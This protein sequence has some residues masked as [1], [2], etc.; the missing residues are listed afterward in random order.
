MFSKEGHKASYPVTLAEIQS[1]LKGFSA[2]KSPG[3]DGWPVEFFQVFFDLAG[4]DIL[5]MVEET[6][7]EGRVSD[8]LNVTFLALIPKSEKPTSFGGFRPIALC[9]LTYKIITK[10]IVARI[11]SSLSFEISKEQFGFL[12]GRQITDA[13]GVVQGSFIQYQGK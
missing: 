4:N 10:I 9:N 8:A 1:T 3:P 13:I 2:S 6:R 5:D 11:K 7:K 12:E